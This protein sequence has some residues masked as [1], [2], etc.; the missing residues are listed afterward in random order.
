MSLNNLPSL[1]N[2][3]AE[4]ILIILEL[5]DIKSI[6]QISKTCKFL[7]NFT[8]EIFPKDHKQNENKLYVKEF[9][10]IYIEKS[11]FVRDEEIFSNF[12]FRINFTKYNIPKIMFFDK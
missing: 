1:I 2:L 3:P 10:I 6:F 4:L 11:K 5:I 8:K 12:S 9:L 7:Y